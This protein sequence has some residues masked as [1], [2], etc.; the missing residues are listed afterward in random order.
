LT[1]TRRR[2]YQTQDHPEPE[3]THGE[4]AGRRYQPLGLGSPPAAGLPRGSW[5]LRLP[6]AR[7][8]QVWCWPAAGP[9]AQRASESETSAAS[10]AEGETVLKSC[11][12]PLSQTEP[13]SPTPDGEM[14]FLDRGTLLFFHSGSPPRVFFPDCLFVL[15]FKFAAW[16]PVPRKSHAITRLAVNRAALPVGRAT[17]RFVFAEH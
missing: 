8:F 1:A 12:C 16:D 14:A 15:D 11:Y 13:V 3:C 7:H 4:W 2:I 5:S 9:K 17:K 6:A 10:A